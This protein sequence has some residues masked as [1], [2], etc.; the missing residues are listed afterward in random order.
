MKIS[1]TEVPDRP[2][3]ANQGG[4]QSLIRL[5]EEPILDD[6]Q[7]LPEKGLMALKCHHPRI[8]EIYTVMDPSG[9]YYRARLAQLSPF[10]AMMIPFYAC[11]RPVESAVHL[12]VY[13]ALPE[14]ERFELIL[15]KLTELGVNRMVPFESLRSTTLRQREARQKKSHRWPHV[16]R[17]AV[18]QCRRA[19]IPE[20]FPILQWDE[21]VC[22]IRSST[23]IIVLSEKEAQRGL[24]EV[25]SDIHSG[26]ISLVVGPEGGLEASEVADVQQVG[27]YS[28]SLGSR[29]LRTETAAI[30][31][32]A[33]IQHEIGGF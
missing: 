14:K 1:L 19:M 33:L 30:V 31:G 24:K 7:I 20:L 22:M 16:L 4:R 26:T 12:H 32:A 13:Q 11:P 25:L 3:I 28:V 6:P 18:R 27:G 29:I 2:V 21:V 5:A 9:K 17:R 10:K 8:G 15:E 23:R